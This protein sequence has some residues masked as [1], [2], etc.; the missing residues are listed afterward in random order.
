[1]HILFDENDDRLALFQ[2]RILPI[3][4]PVKELADI[5]EHMIQFR[6]GFLLRM[7]TPFHKNA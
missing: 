4:T 3:T 2:K 7:V 6:P 1:V 5:A